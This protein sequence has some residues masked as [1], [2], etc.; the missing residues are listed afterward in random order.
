MSALNTLA[1]RIDLI[2]EW[3]GKIAAGAVLAAVLITFTVVILRYGFTALYSIALQESAMY[4]HAMIFMLGA[5]YT[6]KH[7]EHVRVDIFYQT[8]SPQKRAAVN[9]V[10]AL[11]LLIPVCSFI[12]WVSTGYVVDSW[13]NLEGSREAGG[14]PLVFILKSLIPLL[15]ILLILQAISHIIHSLNTFRNMGEH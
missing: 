3:L 1:A 2:N 5:A 6:L 8:F 14:L 13:E 7:D 9:I 4:F 11:F 10:G 12:I 15:A